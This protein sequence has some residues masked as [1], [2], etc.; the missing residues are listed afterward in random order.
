MLVSKVNVCVPAQ[1]S[2]LLFTLLLSLITLNWYL[3]MYTGYG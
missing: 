2:A 1:Y 3:T